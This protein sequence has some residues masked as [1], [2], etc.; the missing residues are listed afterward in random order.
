[1]NTLK[2]FAGIVWMAL[3][4]VSMFYL[5]KTAAEEVSQKPGLDTQIQWSV[6][7]L[8]FFPIAVGVVVFG[9]YALKGE[10]DSSENSSK[11]ISS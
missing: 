5:I 3:G 1:M 6:F 2:R 8:I 7:V 11:G 4:P 9:Y 10:Y